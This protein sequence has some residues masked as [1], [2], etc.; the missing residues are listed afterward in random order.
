MMKFSFRFCP[1][2]GAP[3]EERTIGDQIEPVCSSTACG[4]IFWQNS[5][6]C[7]CIVLENDRG[8][9]LLCVRAF[10]PDKGKLDLPGGFL[11][12]AEHPHDAIHRE[13]REELGVEVEIEAC[14]GFVI[15]RYDHEEVATLNIPFVG[16][17]ARGTPQPADDVEAVHWLALDRIDRKRLAFRNNEVILFDLYRTYREAKSSN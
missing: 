17:I 8:E 13:I 15:D 7:T 11:E 9:I 3:L 12:W 1:K 6:P 14:L 2:C 16:R 4:Y 10:D 5:K